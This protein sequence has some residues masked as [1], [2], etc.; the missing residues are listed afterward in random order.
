MIER[1]VFPRKK[2]VM[3]ICDVPVQAE[4]IRGD[5]YSSASNL[6]LLTSLRTGKLTNYT[7]ESIKNEH[8]INSLDI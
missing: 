3:V 8:G 4:I 5:K 6:G 1:A 2:D 7:K